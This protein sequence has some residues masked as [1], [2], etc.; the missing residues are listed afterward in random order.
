MTDTEI[1]YEMVDPTAAADAAPTAS[2]KQLF[3]DLAEL[4]DDSEGRAAVKWGTLED[5]EF[6][7]DGT[8]ALFPDEPADEDMGLWS[9]TQSDGSGVFAEPPVLTLAFSAAHTSVGLSLVFSEPTGD[10]CSDL[11][12][13]WYGVDGAKLGERKFTLDSASYFCDCLMQDYYKLEIV[14]RKTN[15]PHRFLKLFQVVYGIVEHL[16]GGRITEAALLEEVDPMSLTVSVN[17]F[18]FGFHTDRRFDLLELTGAYAVFQQQQRVTVRQ[19]VDG[20]LRDMGLFFTNV[21][22]VFNQ[23]VVAI[24]CIDWV[25]VIDQTDYM[26]GLWTDGISAGELMADI[27]QSAGVDNYE[28]APELAGVTV[29]GYLPVCSH[30]KALQQLAFAVGGMVC[31]VRG[32]R[33]RMVC[34][35]TEISAVITSYDKVIGHRQTQRKFVSGVEVYTHNYVPA[36]ST[37]ELFKAQCKVGVETVKFS[38]AS[39]LSC[40]GA[41]ILESGVNYAKLSVAAAGIVTLTGRGY[42]DQ[43]S[44]GGSVYAE[45]LPAGARANVKVVDDA[46]LTADAQATAERLYAYYRR[47]VEDKGSLFPVSAA[48]GDMVEMQNDG[49]TLTGIVESMEIDL[50]GG[51]IGEAVIVGG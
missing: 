5:G 25:G 8:F 7:L 12:V 24:D 51:G 13:L 11:S 2:D 10:W 16:R 30:R 46:T 50:V 15:H 35:P 6:R 47:R 9:Q 34:P 20:V 3:V 41:T 37:R 23:H 32:D 49:K 48:T 18:R 42:D 19:R 28:I 44:L 22:E 40:S 36:E 39:S 1:S 17:T 33:L 21:P 27:M 26:G 45:N 31:C 38:A 4:H 29:K 43:I 14:F